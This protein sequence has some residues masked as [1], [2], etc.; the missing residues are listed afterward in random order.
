MSNRPIAQVARS[1]W[2]LAMGLALAVLLFAV[3]F[4]VYRRSEDGDERRPPPAAGEGDLTGGDRH[5][6]EERAVD[7]ADLAAGHERSDWQTSGVLKLIAGLLASMVLVLAA[8]SAF[9][10]VFVGPPAEIGPAAKEVSNVTAVPVPTLVVERATF[11]ETVSQ[12]RAAQEMTLHSYGWIDESAGIVHIPINRAMDIVLERG[13]P[14][15]SEE[16]AGRFRDNALRH[17]SDS[18]SGRMVEL[19]WPP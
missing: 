17:P 6:L 10:F 11:N 9:Q 1:H 5:S 7:P 2:P 12:M 8:V 18:S 13:L 3:T 19:Q 15:R 14:A 4:H 16:E